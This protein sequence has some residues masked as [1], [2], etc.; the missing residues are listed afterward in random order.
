MAMLGGECS[1]CCGDGGGCCYRESQPPARTTEANCEEWG[2]GVLRLDPG[3]PEVELP[4]PGLQGYGAYS[5][6][7]QAQSAGDAW[8]AGN[9]QE[10]QGF[11]YAY[12]V[13]LSNF[14]AGEI[15]CDCGGESLPGY[16]DLSITNFTTD[17][18]VLPNFFGNSTF[19]LPLGDEVVNSIDGSAARGYNYSV[20]PCRTYSTYLRSSP[21]GSLESTGVSARVSAPFLGQTNVN[22]LFSFAYC[23]QTSP[24]GSVVPSQWSGFTVQSPS[25]HPATQWSSP[26]LGSECRLPLTTS[27]SVTLATGGDKY[28][29]DE[30]LIYTTS[31]DY[32]I[33]I[34]SPS[35]P[36]P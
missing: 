9:T 22:F 35:N 25:F 13:K 2:W 30:G 21:C 26:F 36:L 34:P 17:D 11:Y 8:V 31:F 7:Q 29:V 24:A 27:G 3:F 28:P 6:Q 18:P 1:P 14:D 20:S 19:R 23:R 16:A 32:T 15:C 10:L 33:T 12:T 4:F 5:T